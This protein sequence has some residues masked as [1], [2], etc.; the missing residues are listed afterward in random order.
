MSI[1]TRKR[2]K[3][4]SDE[5]QGGAPHSRKNTKYLGVPADLYEALDRYRVSK[6]DEDD[7]KSMSWAGR[8][9][10]RK[11]L[12]SVGFWPPAK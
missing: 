1:M 5:Q 4:E 3:A 2:K 11:F 9:A 8:H 10:L 6:S 7:E 12:E